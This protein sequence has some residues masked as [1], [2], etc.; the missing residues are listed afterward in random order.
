MRL[1]AAIARPLPAVLVLAAVLRF[2]EIDDQPLW[3]DEAFSHHAAML[4]FR[5]LWLV[6][7][8][9]DSHPALYYTLLKLWTGLFGSGETGLRGLS[10]LSGVATVPVL[11][12]AGRALGPSAEAGR[13]L[14]IM[15]AL[16]FALS[17]LHLAYA[18]EA[19][20]YA[21]QTFAVALGLLGVL[22]LMRQP[23]LAGMRG[24]GWRDDGARPE[25]RRAR[26]A[27]LSVIAGAA[28]TLWLH[29]LGVLFVAAL[30]PP[31][32]LWCGH[33][34]GRPVPV[35]AN[36]L[37]AAAAVV[38]L[39]SPGLYWLAVQV[40]TV[41]TDFWLAPPNAAA[42][43]EAASGLYA[44]G[45][46][47]SWPLLPL[48]LALEIWGLLWLTRQGQGPQARLLLA[49]A[50]LPVALSLAATWLVRPVFL[51]RTLIWAS[52]P[53]Q[54]ALAAGLVGLPWRRLRPALAALALLPVAAG[55]VAYHVTKHKEPWDRIARLVARGWQDGDRVVLLPG[56]LAMPLAYYWRKDHGRT[57]PVTVLPQTGEILRPEDLALLTD[58]LASVPRIWLVTRRGDLAD[59]EGYVLPRLSAGRPQ[60][61]HE[62]NS[63]ID[64]FLFGPDD[65]T[66]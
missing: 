51:L 45:W 62:E 13:R 48:F 19:R 56:H 10:A 42:L 28:L 1:A 46:P 58:L 61:M 38:L 15:A 31:L 34:L 29:N 50:V 21:P 3:S 39:W 41:A 5:E 22:M 18:Q 60:L 54:L 12:A 23:Q 43:T 9:E 17:P 49:L 20:P 16:L 55:A 36:A 8:R 52:L 53:V 64:L 27:W 59:P 37:L 63:A 7:P 57:F 65:G 24:L 2:H 25:V 40:Q 11:Y 30:L 4:S 35:L 14:G 26:R 66:G 32:L 47:Q 6:L 44:A 33:D